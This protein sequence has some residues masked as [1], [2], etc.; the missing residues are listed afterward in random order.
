[1]LG[2]NKRVG[3]ALLDGLDFLIAAQDGMQHR[4]SERQ[5]WIIV[6]FPQTLHDLNYLK[7]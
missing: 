2:V 4:Q 5:P 3:L 6:C 7:Q 1:M